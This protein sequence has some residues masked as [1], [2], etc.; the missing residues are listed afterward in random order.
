[1]NGGEYSDTSATK[2]T[3]PDSF[4]SNLRS[5]VTRSNENL[6]QVPDE[7]TS[8]ESDLEKEI[9]DRTISDSTKF[10]VCLKTNQQQKSCQILLFQRD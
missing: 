2:M 6:D 5:Y 7:V 4:K 8:S 9:F 10:K 3:A 1:M